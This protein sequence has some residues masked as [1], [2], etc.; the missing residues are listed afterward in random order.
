[1]SG[2]KSFH[3]VELSAESLERAARF[4][5]TVFGWHFEPPP[6]EHATK[7]VMYYEGQPE[8]GL[9]LRGRSEGGAGIRPA[10]AVESIG[11][12]LEAVRDAGGRAVQE[13][14]DVGDGYTGFL[15]DTEGNLLGLW[16][17]K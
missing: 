17:F 9:R 7:D 16:Q 6:E 5:Q 11:R 14:E 4:Y 13:A 1:V 12:T 15:E 3:Y 10:V 2:A 8:V